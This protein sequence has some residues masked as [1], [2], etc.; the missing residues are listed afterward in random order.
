MIYCWR[1]E[2]TSDHRIDDGQSPLIRRLDAPLGASS[3]LY[4]TWVTG[5]SESL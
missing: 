1:V 3:N 2:L 5:I 4:T